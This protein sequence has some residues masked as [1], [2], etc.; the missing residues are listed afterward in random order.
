MKN[1]SESISLTGNCV[2]LQ[3]WF[4]QFSVHRPDVP[5]EC[6]AA[7]CF[8]LIPSLPTLQPKIASLCSI[9]GGY[10]NRVESTMFSNLKYFEFLTW[11]LF[12]RQNGLMF[13]GFSITTVLYSK[14]G[15]YSVFRFLFLKR[16]PLEIS[17]V[18]ESIF[19]D[20]L[21]SIPLVWLVFVGTH[22]CAI[23]TATHSDRW[24]CTKS[25]R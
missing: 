2:S 13:G 12:A 5:G 15:S 24:L 23:S 14:R 6:K 8:Q 19:H 18:F 3:L 7:W 1:K 22:L 10:E 17:Y 4:P 25:R 16:E 9:Y 11:S 21:P 20:L